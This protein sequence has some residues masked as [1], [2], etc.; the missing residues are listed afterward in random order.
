[1][2]TK[3]EPIHPG[4]ILSTEFLDPLGVS[5]TELARAIHVPPNRV[6]RLINGQ[7]AVTPD[8]AL[9]LARALRTTPE[10]WL[11]LQMRFD[12]DMAADAGGVMDD[13]QPI[14]AM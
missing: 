10:F 7:A 11:N 6:T 1:M 14:V 9:R 13:I 5:A 12:L 8:T 3:Y 4:E 2:P